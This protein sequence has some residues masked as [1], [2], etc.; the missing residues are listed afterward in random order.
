MGDKQFSSPNSSKLDTESP[1]S[2]DC[3]YEIDSTISSAS[4]IC[5]DY[6]RIL[7]NKYININ[8]LFGILGEMNNTML[9]MVS[10]LKCAIQEKEKTTIGSITNKLR[11]CTTFINNELN[12][13]KKELDIVKKNDDIEC[14]KTTHLCSRDLKKV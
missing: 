9:K 11:D 10:Q 2:L 13:T 3:M 6:D 12:Y 5:R 8:E 14:M 1:N 4:K 7:Q